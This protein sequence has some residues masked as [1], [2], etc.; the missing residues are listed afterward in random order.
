MVNGGS[1]VAVGVEALFALC[2]DPR[3]LY[4]LFRPMASWEKKEIDDDRDL[5]TILIGGR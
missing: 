2:N 4:D 1:Q 3:D 5:V